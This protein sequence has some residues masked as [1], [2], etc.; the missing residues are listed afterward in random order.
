MRSRHIWLPCWQAAAG[1]RTE[2]TQHRGW[3]SWYPAASQLHAETGA[4]DTARKTWLGNKHPRRAPVSPKAA[5]DAKDP[6]APGADLYHSTAIS[7]RYLSYP[8]ARRYS[9]RQAGSL[10]AISYLMEHCS[11]W[12]TW[13]LLF[14]LSRFWSTAR[15]QALQKRNS[16]IVVSNYSPLP[17]S[18]DPS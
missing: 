2:L 16:A 5:L 18:N 17:F 3:G 10:G 1:G 11:L 6:M 13:Y 7:M 4:G 14:I 8:S 15:D 9:W 12:L